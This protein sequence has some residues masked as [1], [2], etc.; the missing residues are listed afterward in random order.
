MNI[1]EFC[2]PQGENPFAPKSDQIFVCED[3]ILSQDQCDELRDIILRKEKEIM[4]EFPDSGDGH[5][6]LGDSLTSRF[7]HFNLLDWPETEFLGELIK[8]TH[9][10]FLDKL[11]YPND[12]DIYCACWANVMRKG[13]SIDRHSHANNAHAY[14]GGHI[15]VSVKDTHTFYVEPYYKD[16]AYSANETGKITLFPNWIEH[17]TDEVKYDEERVTIAF[18]MLNENG[19]NVVYPDQT[20]R[21][22]KL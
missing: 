10:I 22:K 14:L 15:C 20:F 16:I 6:G 21:W 8:K 17:G 1:I 4:E 3:Y 5:T 7:S 13:Q 9:D 19:Y 12:Q 18:D 2:S 11:G